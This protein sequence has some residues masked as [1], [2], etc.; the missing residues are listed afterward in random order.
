MPSAT[1]QPTWK[2]VPF[3]D[4]TTKEFHDALRLR[5]NIFVVEQNCAYEEIDGKD[6]DCFHVLGFNEGGE[7]VATARIAPAGVIYPH[8]SIGRVVVSEGARGQGLAKRM[9]KEAMDFSMATMK[10]STIKLAA[11]HYLEDFYKSLG[12]NTISEIYP[13]DGIDH[14]DMLWEAEKS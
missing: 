5:V 10:A 14:V 11:Q 6:P 8:V 3:S 12:F 1:A 9:M 2:I 7:L 4:L 13:W